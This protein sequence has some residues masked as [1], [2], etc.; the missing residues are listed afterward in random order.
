MT[1]HGEK[2][3]LEVLEREKHSGKNQRVSSYVCI[4][5]MCPNSPTIITKLRSY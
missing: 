3:S 4:Y 5:I 2:D 1:F